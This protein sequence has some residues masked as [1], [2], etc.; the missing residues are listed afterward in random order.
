M[1]FLVLLSLIHRGLRWALWTT[2]VLS[3]ALVAACGLHGWFADERPAVFPVILAAC[4]MATTWIAI[5][6]KPAVC[7]DV[8]ITRGATR[9]APAYSRPRGIFE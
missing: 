4:T 1:V 2:H 7:L 8:P 5:R 6:V 3:V 9:S